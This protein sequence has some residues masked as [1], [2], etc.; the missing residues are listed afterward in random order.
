MRF[1]KFEV[2]MLPLLHLSFLVFLLLLLSLNTIINIIDGITPLRIHIP[3]QAQN[4]CN[5]HPQL[6]NRKYSNITQLGTHGSPFLGIL[7]IANQNMDIKTQLNSGIRFLQ[8]QTHR[9]AFGTLSLCHTSCFLNN[10]GSL[11]G[12]LK[13][14]KE[15][16][17]THPQEVVTLLLTNGDRL[18]MSE[19][20][21]AFTTSE[22]KS[23]AYI[24]R[25]TGNFEIDVSTDSWPTLGEM[26]ASG[27]RL[28]VFID[29]KTSP[30]LYPYLLNEF[31]YFWET[32]FDAVEPVFPQ[33]AVHRIT[34]AAN[35]KMYI[36]NHFL[37]TQIIKLL[38]PNR[39]DASKTN[40]AAGIGSIGAQV[41]LCNELHGN[42]PA[43]ILVDYFERGDV[44]KVQNTLNGFQ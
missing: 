29:Y 20:D 19:F 33:C 38:V 10:A 42:L 44:L 16:L 9:N 18:N 1:G 26:I 11:Q 13:T 24:P 31:Y 36:I 30:V 41:N 37:D 32:P 17:D 34:A 14:V 27:K 7:P 8:A 5:G 12:Y 35:P 21:H 4:G 23:Y 25:N 3:S 39:R 2:R 6:C 15:W 22:I 43:V 40:A 28:V